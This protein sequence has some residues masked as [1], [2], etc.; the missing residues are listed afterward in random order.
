MHEL[1]PHVLHDRITGSSIEAR[2]VETS[3]QRARPVA[4]A[5]RDFT[6]Y[7]IMVRKKLDDTTLGI[8][9]GADICHS[10][11]YVLGAEARAQ[12]VEMPHAVEYRQD[13]GG[14]TNGLG[15]VIHG[16]IE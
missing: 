4:E 8:H 1:L 3:L 7:E 11:Q 5:A 10:A 12:P 15:E 13:H 9:T 16:F 6:E 14:W 2:T